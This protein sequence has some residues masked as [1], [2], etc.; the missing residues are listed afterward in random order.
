ML[1]TSARFLVLPV[2][3]LLPPAHFLLLPVG[4]LLPARFLRLPCG[5]AAAAAC[6]IPDAAACGRAD[7]ARFLLLPV[8]MLL[9]ARILL[10]PG[11]MLLQPARLL[12]LRPWRQCCRHCLH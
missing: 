4:K 12:P 8:G 10:P 3:V 6:L 2:G 7:A 11:G 5:H 1:P 9:P